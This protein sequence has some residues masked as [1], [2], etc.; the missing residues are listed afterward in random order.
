MNRERFLLGFDFGEFD[1]GD[2]PCAR[3][4]IESGDSDEPTATRSS[5]SSSKKP[6]VSV[7]RLKAA[8]H[9]QIW[10]RGQRWPCAAASAGRALRPDQ[11]A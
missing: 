10:P 11:A 2:E 7:L 5:R 9:G 6:T 8:P 3:P 4:P 1:A